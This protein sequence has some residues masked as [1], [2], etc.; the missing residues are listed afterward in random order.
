MRSALGTT[1][2]IFSANSSASNHHVGATIG[3]FNVSGG[4]TSYSIPIGIAPG[5]AGMERSI[6]SAYSSQA[7]NGLVGMAWSIG[8][9]SHLMFQD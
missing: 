1:F 6:S 8:G 9:R 4:S 3:Q 2:F 5:M 7:G